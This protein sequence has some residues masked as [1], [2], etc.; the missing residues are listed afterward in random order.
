MDN[1]ATMRSSDAE[2]D[3][4]AN[5]LGEH[6]VAGRLTFEEF[7]DRL[8]LVFTAVTHGQLR[9][10]LADLPGS[11]VPGLGVASDDERAAARGHWNRH[12]WTRFATVNAALW[13]LWALGGTSGIHGVG[14]FWPLWITVPWGLRLAR[15]SGR[16]VRPALGGTQRAELHASPS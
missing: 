13:S 5:A 16:R 9:T 6:L 14:T 12:R 1:N 4:A 11:P 2:R 3:R 8:D 15:P 7:E 10:A